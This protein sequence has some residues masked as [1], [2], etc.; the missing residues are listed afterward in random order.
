[1]VNTGLYLI[2]AFGG[3]TL[4][5]IFFSILYSVLKKPMGILYHTGGEYTTYK[6]HQK[7]FSSGVLTVALLTLYYFF[8]NSLTVPMEN[9][10]YIFVALASL[11]G[12]RGVYPLI[13]DYILPVGIYEQGIVT[14]RGMI[15]FTQ[16]KNYD[17]SDSEKRSEANLV[18]LRVY[19]SNSKM[20]GVHG[21]VIDR[22]DKSK[23]QKIMK[24]RMG[25]N[26]L[27]KK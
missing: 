1:M 21:L 8:R 2:C 23:V 19:T 17:F 20:F 6:M 27:Y 18:Y 22:D 7:A 16:I 9:V 14:S 11:I 4:Y 10:M 13:M 12:M 26:K 25:S 15:R 3:C 5:T 24:Q